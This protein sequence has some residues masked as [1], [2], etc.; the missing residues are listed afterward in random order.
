[1]QSK[2]PVEEK[3]RE[4]GKTDDTLLKT[5]GYNICVVDNPWTVEM[6]KLVDDNVAQKRCNR[7]KRHERKKAIK[8]AIKEHATT[9]RLCLFLKNETEAEAPT[10]QQLMSSKYLECYN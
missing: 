7:K 5:L 1:M 3:K 8:R 4:T 6:E 9:S 10:W 2:S